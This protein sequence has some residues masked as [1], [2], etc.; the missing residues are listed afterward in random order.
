MPS[1]APIALFA[2]RRVQH[3]AAT[4]DALALCQGFAESPLFVFSDGAKEGSEAEVEAVR[5]LLQER[6]TPNMT[7]VCSDVNRGL[8]NAIIAGVTHLCDEFGR[9][10]VVED[11]LLAQPSL[12]DWFNAGL[13]RY[14]ENHS[15]WQIAGHQFPVPAFQHRNTGMFLNFATSWG[16]AVWRRSWRHFDASA[17]G[18]EILANDKLVRD[19]FD[20]GGAYPYSTMLEDQML[21]KVNSWAVR[22]WWS[23]FGASALALFPPRS[24]VTNIGDDD[25]ATHRPSR[26]ARLFQSSGKAMTQLPEF[27]ENVELDAKAQAELQQF[28]RSSSG[29]IE[30]IRSLFSHF[31]RKRS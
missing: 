4:L 17:A 3:L 1:K 5:R 19:R 16:W 6:R 7:V 23:M 29:R 28:L 25:T 11:D 2:Y 12:L 24:L 15:V 18:Y 27:P 9:V 10:I 22:W 30:R 13:D 21:G 8:A 31:R 20:F 26:L 14:A